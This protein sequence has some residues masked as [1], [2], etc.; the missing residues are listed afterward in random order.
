MHTELNVFVT[1]IFISY[2]IIIIGINYLVILKLGSALKNYMSTSSWFTNKNEG[3]MPLLLPYILASVIFYFVLKLI[4]NKTGLFFGGFPY[5]EGLITYVVG[6]MCIML[7]RFTFTLNFQP[8]GLLPKKPIIINFAMWVGLSLLMD[9][10][11]KSILEFSIYS[12][13]SFA[14][15]IIMTFV[16]IRKR[17][18]I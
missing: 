10:A 16:L 13:V 8:V 4:E 2:S 1:M 9:L 3:L 6:M 5:G 11:C 18:V 17:N 14:C 12:M 7:T 15:T